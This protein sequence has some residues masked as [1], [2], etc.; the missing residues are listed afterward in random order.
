MITRDDEAALAAASLLGDY[1]D[2]T[3]ATETEARLATALHALL[4]RLPAGDDVTWEWIVFT[5]GPGPDSC[6][7][8]W[9]AGS[10]D[11]ARRKA[12]YMEEGCYAV[13]AVARG[14]WRSC[15]VRV[16]GGVVTETWDDG[17]GNGW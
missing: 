16:A 5:G 2:F 11:D 15:Q 1:G 4:S 3:A 9:E 13:R 14:P 10:E 12:A 6:A 7:I 8:T 17:A